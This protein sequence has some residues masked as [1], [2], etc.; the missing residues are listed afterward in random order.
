[1]CIVCWFPGFQ[2]VQNIHF[3][4]THKRSVSRLRIG[5]NDNPKCGECFK[6]SVKD[7]AGG[8]ATFNETFHFHKTEKM[9]VLTV[10]Q[11][12]ARSSFSRSQ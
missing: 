5:S 3:L 12:L 7:N 11:L 8:T 10:T 2:V 4:Y 6:T 9:N 1:M